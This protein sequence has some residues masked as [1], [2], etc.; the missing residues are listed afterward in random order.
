ML[1]FFGKPFFSMNKTLHKK[2]TA[3]HIYGHTPTF[4][5]PDGEDMLAGLAHEM[6][7]LRTAA[8][9]LMQPRPEAIAGILSMARTI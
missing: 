7:I 2:L 5:F 8:N 6:Y 4:A 1:R 3:K 9:D